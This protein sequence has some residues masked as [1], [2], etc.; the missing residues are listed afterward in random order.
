M[1]MLSNAE[2]Q[3]TVDTIT[4]GMIEP[5]SGW[6][7][8]E[9]A[10]ACVYWCIVHKGWR[11]GTEL[12]M[13]KKAAKE[14]LHR[15][16]LS[17]R[18]IGAIE[19][20]VMNVTSAAQKLL[21]KGL[22][23]YNSGRYVKRGTG[24]DM[25]PMVCQGFAPA[26]NY[27]DCLLQLLPKVL[28]YFDLIPTTRTVNEVFVDPSEDEGSS[29]NGTEG[30]RKKVLGTRVERS[31]KVRDQCL[32]HWGYS[33]QVCGLNFEDR[34]GTIGKDFIHVH[35]LNPVALTGE[36][37]TDPVNDLRPVCPNCHSMLHKK[38][39]PFSLEGLKKMIQE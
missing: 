20:K 14:Q 10:T 8:D 24:K 22:P 26:P 16:P 36:T 39:P 9:A 28:E 23:I 7:L 32:K 1:K 13:T 3:K 31:K 25:G 2:I 21:R 29:E 4:T 27:Q 37:K 12:G 5:S 18:P 19:P 15:G 11:D 35:H 38:Y 17:G 6:S 30:K 34:Y 33:C